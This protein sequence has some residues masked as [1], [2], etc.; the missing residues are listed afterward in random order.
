MTSGPAAPRG[1]ADDPVFPPHFEPL[2]DYRRPTA[3]DRSPPAPARAFSP[4]HYAVS[5]QPS[6]AGCRCFSACRRHVR[7]GL[8]T[9]P[10]SQPP[11]PLAPQRACCAAA[12][13]C[14]R[15]CF[16][17][18]RPALRLGRCGPCGR[19]SRGDQVSLPGGMRRG[20]Y[21]LFGCGDGLITLGHKHRHRRIIVA[22]TPR[23]PR[24]SET[25]AG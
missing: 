17:R 15:G 3:S 8:L 12:S 11:L 21:R 9:V 6:L 1:R 16:G 13:A 23:P 24:L 5:P 4:R 10:P 7:R 18:R 25:L 19:S 14:R 2:E 22:A 20:G